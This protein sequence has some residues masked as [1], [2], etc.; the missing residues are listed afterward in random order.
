VECNG[1]QCRLE[2]SCWENSRLS[3][4]RI[5]SNFDGRT[6]S[7]SVQEEY[8]PL[9]TFWVFILQ[10]YLPVEVPL[11]TPWLTPIN[12]FLRCRSA[13][14]FTSSTKRSHHYR[15]SMVISRR[16]TSLT[17]VGPLTGGPR[18]EAGWWPGVFFG[19]SSF[20]WLVLVINKRQAF[21]GPAQT[22]S[23]LQIMPQD[24]Y[25]SIKPTLDDYLNGCSYVPS[26][27]DVVV[28]KLHYID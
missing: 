22:N 19:D 23:T 7:Q 15:F 16:L 26:G 27:L 4:D 21:C 9:T 8:P 5:W 10:A 20:W 1:S 17:S 14:A 6:K 11:L 28:V 13:P 12:H 24:D 3:V 18:T 2:H 25:Y